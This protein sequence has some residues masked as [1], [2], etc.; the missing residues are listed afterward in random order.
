MKTRMRIWLPLMTMLTSLQLS[1]APVTFAA[2]APEKEPKVLLYQDIVMELLLPDIQNAVN[3]Y[4]NRKLA[5]NP[6]V[7]PYQIDVLQAKRVNGGPGDRGFHFSITLETTP[8]LG[9]HI[10]VGKDRMTFEISPLYSDR[11]KLVAF[12]HLQTFE[13]PSNMQEL[14]KSNEGSP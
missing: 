9:P 13:L 11:I 8:V 14:L 5:E 10:A 1:A 4:Y 6:L 7:Y 2:A 3:H 12:R